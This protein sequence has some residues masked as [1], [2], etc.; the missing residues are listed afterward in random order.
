M[1]TIAHTWRSDA[2]PAPDV[3][4][5]RLGV[6]RI[7]TPRYWDGAN[8]HDIRF[9]RFD[10]IATPF[11]WPKNSRSKMP[12]WWRGTEQVLQHISADRQRTVGWGEP[13]KVF[14]DK[15]VLAHLV[16]TNV[17]QKDWREAYQAEMRAAEKGKP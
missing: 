10:S 16:R 5:T 13:Y 2:P 14:D 4:T 7:T 15:E 9:R 6:S 11:K 3:Y 17:L 1:A 12:A 8:W